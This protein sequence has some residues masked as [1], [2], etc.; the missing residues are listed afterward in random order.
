V[1]VEC[2]LASD[3]RVRADALSIDHSS[4]WWKMREYEI[5]A[6]E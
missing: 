5:E 6:P 1:Y 3:G 2:A 4:L